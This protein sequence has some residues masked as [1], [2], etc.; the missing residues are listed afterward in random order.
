MRI[1]LLA[2]RLPCPP[3]KGERIRTFNWLR[4]LAKQNSVSLAA[5]ALEPESEAHGRELNKHCSRIKVVPMR[6]WKKKLL[7]LPSVFSRAPLTL[8][9]FHSTTMHRIAAAMARDADVVIGACSSM[10]PYALG[11]G[12]RPVVLDL[13]DVDS[14][15]WAQYAASARPPFSWVYAREAAALRW[16]E[17]KIAHE[18][19]ACVVSTGAEAELHHRLYGV[20]PT[21]I[22][23]GVD[24][25]Y[26]K[27]ENNGRAGQQMV[28]AGSMDYRPNVDAV[29]YFVRQV[30]PLVKRR[31]PSA[32][33]VVVGRNP[34]RRILSLGRRP[35]ILV[36]GE[37]PDV[38]PYVRASAMSV[39]P[40]TMAF[41]LQNKILEAMATGLP[42]VATPEAVK[43]LDVTPGRDL[44]VAEGAAALADAVIFLLLNPE[45]R[46]RYGAA[47][48]L[49]VQQRYDWSANLRVLDE[50]L[51]RV[52]ESA[53]GRESVSAGKA[54]ATGLKE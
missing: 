15:K 23:N 47:A 11:S 50:L 1:L 38:R 34:P 26:F 52:L 5:F 41:G 33:F 30:L 54:I 24:A 10:A 27:P 29:V 20:E 14:E 4:H 39:A 28:F 48:R 16:Y 32:R 51:A 43:G 31:V 36:T 46:E 35:D 12:K 9:C 13:M 17:E 6:M 2:H 40:F 42:V 7:A 49:R 25:D 3:D 45:A 21:V 18:A 44:V 8:R 37:V 19:D 53:K 22:R